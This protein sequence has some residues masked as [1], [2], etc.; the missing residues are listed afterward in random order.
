MGKTKES[1]LFPKFLLSNMLIFL[2]LLQVSSL[3]PVTFEVAN[4]STAAL[5]N[6]RKLLAELTHRVGLPLD[7]KSHLN[8][9]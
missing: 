2:L 1:S 5:E 3:T 6:G 8:L 4:P 7:G 9:I